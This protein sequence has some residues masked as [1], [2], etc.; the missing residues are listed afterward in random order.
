M[1][2]ESLYR[3]LSEVEKRVKCTPAN[4]P[5]QRALK[6]SYSFSGLSSM[7]QLV[8][9]DYIWN[10]STDFW[11]RVQAFLFLES[12]MKDKQF[13]IV[14]WDVIRKWQETVDHWGHCDALSKIYTRVLELIP[15]RVMLQLRRWNKSARLWD[16]RQSVV[17]LLYFSRTK[18]VF[19]PFKNI[20]VLISA[21]INDPEYYVQKAVGWSLKELY[22]IYPFK[23]FRLLRHICSDLSPIAFTI[24]IEKLSR[25]QKRELKSVRRPSRQ[26][27]KVNS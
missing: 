5:S 4:A 2:L 15:E 3:Y 24:A 17:S 6:Q 26:F 8:I 22:N 18:K 21:L 19:L 9:W 7:E 23:T 11:I 14:A 25:S 20:I 1:N 16:R 12:R 10:N 13:L 27:K